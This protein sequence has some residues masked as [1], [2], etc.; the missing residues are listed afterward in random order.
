MSQYELLLLLKPTLSEEE[1][2]ALMDELKARYEGSLTFQTQDSWGKKRLAYPVQKFKEGIYILC[3]I[4][5]DTP[6][7]N[8]LESYMRIHDSI[9]RFMFVKVVKR[10]KSRFKP[11]KPRKPRPEGASKDNRSDH[12]SHRPRQH[13]SE[14]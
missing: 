2:T 5:T 13:R 10:A 6:T 8:E 12:R 1:V 11:R 14:R 7:L 3:N 4:L 9:M